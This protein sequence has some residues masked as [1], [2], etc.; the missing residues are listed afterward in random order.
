MNR[1]IKILMIISICVNANTNS[2][3]LIIIGGGKRPASVMEKF[4]E[5]A[6]SETANILIIPMASSD[7]IG[8]AEYQVKEMIS[9]GV[10]KVNIINITREEANKDSVLRYLDGIT[11]IFISGGDQNRLTKI[12]LNTKFLKHMKDY[13]NNGGLIAGTSAGAAVMSKVMITGDEFKNDDPDKAFETI[14]SKNIITSEGFG[15]LDNCIVDQHFIARRRHNRLIS[16]VLDN[17]NLIGIA[18]DESTAVLVTNGNNYEVF[19]ESQVIV[20]DARK[21]INLR[22]NDN[23]KFSAIGVIMDILTAGD[24]YEIRIPETGE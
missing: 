16:L 24:T 4:I 15:F 8:T 14:E 3:K 20:Y 6:G 17:P 21:S 22:I 11:G 2:G 18:I 23:G 10:S 9:Y 7:P 1:V 12:L 19:G 13:Y 5:L